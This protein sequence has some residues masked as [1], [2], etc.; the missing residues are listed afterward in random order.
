MEM[1]STEPSNG[2]MYSLSSCWSQVSFW[3]HGYVDLPMFSL[4]FF[5]SVVA[6]ALILPRSSRSVKWIVSAGLAQV[7]EFS[8]V[9]GSRAR[10]LGL[11]TREVSLLIPLRQHI[12][13]GAYPVELVRL[14]GKWLLL[15]NT[16]SVS[17]D[18]EMIQPF[19]IMGHLIGSIFMVI[20]VYHAYQ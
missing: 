2:K 19:P 1:S 6:L 12:T 5:I 8:F 7:S 4:Q 10:R 15:L 11:I 18:I 20:K 3:L 16:T 14:R 13:W 9:L 17:Y